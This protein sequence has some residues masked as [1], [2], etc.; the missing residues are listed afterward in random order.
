MKASEICEFPL[1]IEFQEEGLPI[2]KPFQ[3]NRAAMLSWWI[4]ILL[5]AT[6]ID[7]VFTQDGGRNSGKFQPLCATTRRN[8]YYPL[9]YHTKHRFTI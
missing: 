5:I 9:N 1:R 4:G 2:M 3:G 6:Q 7:I 8:I